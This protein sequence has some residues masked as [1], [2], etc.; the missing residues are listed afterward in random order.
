MNYFCMDG[1]YGSSNKKSNSK[2]V[3]EFKKQHQETCSQCQ[4]REWPD[5]AK[6]WSLDYGKEDKDWIEK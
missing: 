3:E 5:M 6:G 1:D 2:C 4:K